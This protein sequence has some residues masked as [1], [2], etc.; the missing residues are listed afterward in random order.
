MYEWGKKKKEIWELARSSSMFH[1]C[2]LHFLLQCN[3][4][5]NKVHLR[6]HDQ[7]F[8]HIYSV[9]NHSTFSFTGSMAAGESPVIHRMKLMGMGNASIFSPCG[10]LAAKMGCTVF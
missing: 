10:H 8:P 9:G 7:H 6:N 1:V 3:C 5:K 4:S 2:F